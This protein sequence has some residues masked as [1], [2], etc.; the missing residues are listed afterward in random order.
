MASRVN[1]DRRM[2]SEPEIAMAALLEFWPA[3]LRLLSV[4]NLGDEVG[5]PL[6]NFRTCQG[7]GALT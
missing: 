6:L 4:P 1:R 2:S 3:E 5:K 7:V